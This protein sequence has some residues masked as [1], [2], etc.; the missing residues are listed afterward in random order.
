[1][2][3]QKLLDGAQ[4]W[5]DSAKTE[6]SLGRRRVAF[7]AARHAAE[8]AA[9]AILVH[10][11]GVYPKSHLVAGALSKLGALPGRVDGRRLHRLLAEFTLGTYG[12]DREVRPEDVDEALAV[13]GL[14]VEGARKEVPAA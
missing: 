11:Q 6:A 10:R 9:K 3:A 4:E 2:N 5:L 1:M 8:L 14:M 13:A 12:F 7:E